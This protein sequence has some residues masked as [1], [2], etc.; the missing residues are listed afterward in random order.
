[1]FHEMPFNRKHFMAG[2]KSVELVGSESI[3]MKADCKEVKC[4]LDLFDMNK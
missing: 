1:M 4:H 3:V 2:K